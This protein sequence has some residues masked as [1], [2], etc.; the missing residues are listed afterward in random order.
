MNSEKCEKNS[1]NLHALEKQDKMYHIQKESLFCRECYKAFLD[2]SDLKEHKRNVH[3][4]NFGCQPC[5]GRFSSEEA[6]IN[7]M[8][9]NHEC[10]TLET[11]FF[12]PSVSN[13]DSSFIEGEVGEV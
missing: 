11:T 4:Q 3:V 1:V 12:N 13:P 8:T 5:E 6:L 10:I 2:A 9:E 7:H